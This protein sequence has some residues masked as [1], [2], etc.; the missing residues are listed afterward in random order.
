MDIR[1]K[2]ESWL[3]DPDI[4]PET[5]KELE[6]IRDDEK[7]IEDRFYT[8][9][10]FGTAGLRGVLGAGLNRMNKYIVC[11]ATQGLADYINHVFENG[12]N[13]KLPARDAAPEKAV[14]IAYDSR[15][16]SK[17]FSEFTALCLNAN[18]IKTYVFEG[19]RPT[20]ELSF[21][22]RHFN[23][24]S[25]VNI[26][27]SHN[28]AEYNGYKVYWADGAQV[29]P[30]H[31]QGIMDC[32]QAVK[33]FSKPKLM[34]RSEA[35]DAGLYIS[36]GT[37]VD[38]LYIQEISK[39]IK[40]P[41]AIKKQADN[42]K[43]AYTPLHGTG[44]TIIPQAL[45]MAGFENVFTVPE[46]AEPDGDFPTVPYPNPETPK[47]FELVEALAKQVGADIAIATD[48]DADRIG[49]HVRDKNG[50]Y[51]ELSG[52][53]IGALLCEYELSRLSAKGQL[54]KDGIVIRS[55]VSSDL[56][57]R[58]ADAYGVKLVE[59]LTGFKWIGAEILKMEE[60]GE[61]T[62]IFGFEES[63]GYL[64][65][66]YARDK[67]SCV[68][69]LALSEACAYYKD[70]G[71]TMWD[72]V[73]EMFKKYGFSVEETVSVTMK[74]S[75][76]MAAIQNIMQGLRDDPISD[77]A[78]YKINKTRDYKKPEETGLPKS[79]VLYYELDDAWVAV[80]PS[81]TEPKIKYYFGVTAETKEAAEEK[82]DR[83]KDALVG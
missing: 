42:I 13:E 17:E 83:L 21:A 65:G 5:K 75:D 44:I 2:Y 69:A 20:P 47:A 22:V 1:K 27:A 74:G 7:E 34:D 50:E 6:E 54:P 26:T 3:N 51:H 16:M 63:Y 40:E 43:I 61:G 14:A 24:I 23:C 73:Q 77:I 67:D 60:S 57:D 78:G 82:K 12:L 4:D 62:Y 55:I 41:E 30:P 68:A 58:I 59:V 11:R 56:I 71:M 72:A 37:E 48:P 31:D 25:G 70:C 15:H 79:D 45:K 33:D 36:I 10:E 39:Q 64:I 76:G 19:L 18:G 32:V 46:Q 66:T 81:G 53:V 8:E 29:T 9:L 52:N 38:L 35:V 49:V 80:R 28:P